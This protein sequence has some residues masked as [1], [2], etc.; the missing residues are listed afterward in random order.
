MIINTPFHRIT[1]HS[2]NAVTSHKPW[3]WKTPMKVGD[4]L[5]IWMASS[6]GFSKTTVTEFVRAA[7]FDGSSGALF[8]LSHDGI[9]YTVDQHK[10]A[11]VRRT[12][13]TWIHAN[14]RNAEEYAARYDVA[15]NTI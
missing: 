14:G 3:N 2:R 13:G 1:V 8:I 9:A 6:G 4:E 11:V 15:N 12:N 5:Y 7:C 10:D